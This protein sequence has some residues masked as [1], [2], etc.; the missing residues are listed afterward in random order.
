MKEQI[1]IA[2]KKKGGKVGGKV[3]RWGKLKCNKLRFSCS[4]VSNSVS[5]KKVL[6]FRQKMGKVSFSIFFVKKQQHCLIKS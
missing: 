3:Q 6:N 4:N 2:S 5:G 1:E